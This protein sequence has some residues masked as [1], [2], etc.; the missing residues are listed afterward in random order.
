MA[1]ALLRPGRPTPFS[2]LA[3]GNTQHFDVLVDEWERFL[4]VPP[5]LHDYFRRKHGDLFTVEYWANV[6]R[7]APGE[8][9]YVAP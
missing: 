1:H 6:Q 3:S 2:T 5:D 7:R 8:F 4:G 9:H